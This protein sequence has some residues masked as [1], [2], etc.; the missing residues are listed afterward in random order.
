MKENQ[1]D[2]HRWTRGW[3]VKVAPRYFFHFHLC[4]FF[5]EIGYKIV[6]RF[7]YLG[8]T[9]PRLRNCKSATECEQNELITGFLKW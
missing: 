6:R 9:P 4:G 7:A 8:R 3:V 2:F 5:G 1:E